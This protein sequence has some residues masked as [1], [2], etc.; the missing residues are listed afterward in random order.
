MTAPLRQQ[1]TF[2]RR[3]TAPNNPCQLSSNALMAVLDDLAQPERFLWV[4]T[5]LATW[6]YTLEVANVYQ[7]GLRN[8]HPKTLQVVVTLPL[9]AQPDCL[10]HL[11][12]AFACCCYP[13]FPLSA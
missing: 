2:K 9:V 5:L 1:S 12:S 4:A 11:C 8:P 7:S 13:C 3:T 10:H 6:H